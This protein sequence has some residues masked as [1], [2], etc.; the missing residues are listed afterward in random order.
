M[1]YSIVREQGASFEP[2]V[3]SAM[4][5][6]YHAAL[7]ELG[8]TESD[9]AATRIVAKKVIELA[10]RGERDPERLKIATLA[11]LGM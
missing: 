8:L 1:F 2:E 5:A 3:I 9:D 10:G 6:A 4:A 7:S 11:A